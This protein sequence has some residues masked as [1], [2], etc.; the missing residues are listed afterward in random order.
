METAQFVHAFEAAGLGIAP[1]E[2]VGEYDRGR[3]NQTSCDLCGTGIRYEEIIRDA[4]G[5]TFKVGNE[6][7]HK[8]GDQGLID[9]VKV[10]ERERRAK[11]KAAKEAAELDAQRARNGGKTNAEL[12]MERQAAKAA[13]EAAKRAAEQ[14]AA[15][16]EA[17]AAN[18]ELLAV[19]APMIADT[20]AYRNRQVAEFG[21]TWR[22]D[23][24]APFASGTFM[25]DMWESLQVRP[26]STLTYRQKEVLADIVAKGNMRAAGKRKREPFY[27]EVA[28]ALG[29]PE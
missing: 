29:L 16:A 7:V 5:H 6:C 10:A 27:N 12:H 14:E 18:A 3:N 28:K 22:C 15:R 24:S 11:A 26:H 8:T 19:M 1:F 9:M 20:V 25:A 2:F 23:A 17:K 21:G 4:K 13:E